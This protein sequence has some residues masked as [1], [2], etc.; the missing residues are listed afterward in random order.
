MWL[1]IPSTTS[2]SAPAE[3]DSISPSSWQFQVLERSAWSKGKPMPSQSWAK[4]WRKASWLQRLCGRMCEPSTADHGVALWMASLA[5]SRVSPT[6]KPEKCSAKTTNA[7]CGPTPGGSSSSLAR[8]TSGSR[9]SKASSATAARGASTETY[10]GLAA[11]LRSDFSLRQKLALHR[12][13]PGSS[14]SLWP[15][16]AARDYRGA[17]SQESQDRRNKDSKRGQQLPNFVMHVLPSLWCAPT[18]AC[19]TGGQRSRSGDRKDE[20][21]LGG[22]ALDVSSRLGRTTSL[23]GENTSTEDLTLNPPF[24][25]DL[26]GWPTGLSA[27]E[28][29]ETELSRWKAVMRFAMSQLPLPSEAP[30]VQPGLFG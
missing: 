9:T 20:L 22:Q 21:L 4:T 5:A 25:E 2:A 8:G 24:V 23:D 1:L 14:S 12:A 26:M 15:I 7:T 10:S 16:P 13:G 19:S 11:R 29:S 18:V 27:S 28:C 17:N 6:A 3:P 30:S